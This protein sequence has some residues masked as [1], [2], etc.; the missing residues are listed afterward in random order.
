M[1]STS[2]FILEQ[3]YRKCDANYIIIFKIRCPAVYHLLGCIGQFGNS[4]STFQKKLLPQTL[5]FVSWRWKQHISPKGWPKTNRL[6]ATLRFTV[7]DINVILHIPRI[8]LLVR[9]TTGCG[10]NH[11]KCTIYKTSAIEK[12]CKDFT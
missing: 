12:Y 2:C 1:Y 6:Y 5:V 9:V 4:L 11:D 10:I 7:I 3:W 8:Q